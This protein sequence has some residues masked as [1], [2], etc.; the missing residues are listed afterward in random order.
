MDEVAEKGL[1]AHWKY[2]G[3]KS[4]GE[5]DKWLIGN[6]GDAREPGWRYQGYY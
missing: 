4:S 2:K 5:L 3:G 6:A 1:A